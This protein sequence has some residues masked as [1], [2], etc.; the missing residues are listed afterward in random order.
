MNGAA[1][2]PASCFPSIKKTYG[3]PLQHWLDLIARQGDQLH[4]KLVGLLKETHGP[5]HGHAS[6]LVADALSQKKGV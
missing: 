6:A 1:E 3:G 2:G 4:M 5:C